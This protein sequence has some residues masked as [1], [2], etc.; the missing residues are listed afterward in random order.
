MLNS[1]WLRVSF[2]ILS[3]YLSLITTSLAKDFGELDMD[4]AVKEALENN[5]RMKEVIQKELSAIEEKK[6]ISKDLLFKL[7]TNYSYSRLKEEP[8]TVFPNESLNMLIDKL[9][10]LTLPGVPATKIPH[11]P[12]KIAVAEK[13][14]VT[15]EFTLT[16][17]IFTGFALINRKRIAELG[18]DLVQY[19]KE[20]AALELARQVKMAYLNV[21]LSKRALEIAQDEVAQLEAH[22]R[23][24]EKFYEEGV[25]ARNDLLKSKV[26]LANAQQKRVK[27]EADLKTATSL[28][29]ILLGRPIE[30]ATKV[31]ELEFNISET[32]HAEPPYEEALRNRPE[33][34]LVETR[35]KQ[36]G[37][38]IEIAKSSH[39]PQVY[40]VGQY[41]R[42][43][44][45]LSASKNDFGNDHNASISVVAKLS[46]FE[47]GKTQNEIKKAIHNKAQL[48]EK[49]KELKD[50][51]LTEVKQAFENLKVAAA[52]IETA[53]AA[54]LQARENF[55]ITNLQY[56]EGITTST[57]VLDARAYLT[58]AENNYFRALYGY[59]LAEADLLKA[60]G[61][62]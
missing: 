11:M 22:V 35:L 7:S 48:E 28:L 17:P 5:P 37:L 33:I 55:R 2:I 25:V 27:A 3:C 49:L 56:Q 62:K 61:K 12:D 20:V 57:E 36:A 50:T 9:N 51:I 32:E 23:D 26:A 15:W 14:R 29:N 34:T 39:Y 1:F 30:E 60:L 24:A 46:L 4:S 58:Q 43:G 44:E 42:V 21:L 8:Y 10:A 38:A 52:T 54:R 19:E 45:D 47:W 41:Q 16:Q 18:V 13:E 6:S 40:L 31:K 53:K 59:K